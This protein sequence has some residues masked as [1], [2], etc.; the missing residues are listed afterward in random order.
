MPA[1]DDENFN[2]KVF[3]DET[4]GDVRYKTECQEIC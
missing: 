1:F 2:E 4:F 3:G